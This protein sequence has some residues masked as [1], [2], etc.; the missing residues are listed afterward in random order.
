M[1]EDDLKLDGRWLG[2]V[3]IGICSAGMMLLA[4]W[5]LV[6]LSHR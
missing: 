2:V 1:T 3:I 4:G 6:W 5:V